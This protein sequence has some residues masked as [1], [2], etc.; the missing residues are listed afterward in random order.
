MPGYALLTMR[1]NGILNAVSRRPDVV[2]SASAGVI[3]TDHQSVRG[4]A[5][6]FQPAAR[7]RHSQTATDCGKLLHRILPL[8]IALNNPLSS[9]W[10][11]AH[12]STCRKACQRR[13]AVGRN[14]ADAPRWRIQQTTRRSVPCRPSPVHHRHPSDD[15]PAGSVLRTHRSRPSTR[16]TPS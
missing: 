11:S 1:S 13:D 10:K 14:A 6:P 7:H 2:V 9:A 15:L 5:T 4:Y 3:I 8:S 12:S 16:F